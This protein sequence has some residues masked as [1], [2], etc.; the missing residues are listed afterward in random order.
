[1]KTADRQPGCLQQNND[2]VQ[3]G[4]EH[5]VNSNESSFYIYILTLLLVFTNLELHFTFTLG[6]VQFLN[7]LNLFSFYWL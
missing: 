1:M 4:L 3:E 7:L 6:L 5:T 2:C